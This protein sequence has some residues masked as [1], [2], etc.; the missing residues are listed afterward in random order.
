MVPPKSILSDWNALDNDTKRWQSIKDNTSL[1]D[2]LVVV[3]DNGSTHV[4]L[5]DYYTDDA[6]DSVNPRL[7]G[8]DSYIGNSDGVE[9]LLDTLGIACEH[10]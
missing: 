9:I 3:L 10:C 6:Q 4:R 2:G 5:S 7:N 8:F 1:N